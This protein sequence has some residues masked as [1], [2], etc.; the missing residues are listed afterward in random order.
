MNK[1]LNAAEIKRLHKLR[2]A[3]Y[4]AH[5]A[6]RAVL[7]KCRDKGS[8]AHLIPGQGREEWTAA[9]DLCNKIESE[10]MSL[11]MKDV[12]FGI[13]EEEDEEEEDE[14][15]RQQMREFIANDSPEEVERKSEDASIVTQARAR[16]LALH[17]VM[18][19]SDTGFVV[20]LWDG[21]DGTW[22][23]CGEPH[24]LLEG[25]LAVWY[26]RTERGTK[27]V[28]F[29]EI[30]YFRIFPADTRMHYSEGREMFRDE[31]D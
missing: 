16:Y 28:A 21:M 13:E 31:N 29:N 20:R 2:A 17:R 6:E 7:R 12:G 14:E 26:Q 1:P 11:V 3:L 27:K 19:E 23:D 10:L 24:A 8:I 25:A 9:K 18:P 4:E 22:C 5:V 30:D 15:L